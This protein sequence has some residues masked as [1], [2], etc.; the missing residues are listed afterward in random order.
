MATASAPGT[1]SRFRLGGVLAVA[2][3]ALWCA[4]GQAAA[5]AP[6]TPVRAPAAGQRPAAARVFTGT[7]AARPALAET[8][9]TKP[10]VFMGLGTMAGLAVLAGAELVASA[11]RR[12]DSAPPTDRC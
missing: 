3:L 10:L 8:T 5:V 1:V 11:R 7:A 12:R 9:A 6:R 2:L 4:A